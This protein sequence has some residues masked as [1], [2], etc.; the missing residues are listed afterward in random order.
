MVILRII[1]VFILVI[2]AYLWAIMPRIFNKPSKELFEKYFYA[3][4]GLY[5][6]KGDAPENSEKAFQKAV[7]EG[8]GIELDIQLSKD[9]IPVVFHD[10]SLKRVCKVPGKIEDYMLEE[11]RQFKLL[12]SSE[13][14]PT[15]EEVLKL[16]DG[17]VP[18]IIEIKCASHKMEICQIVY[19]QMKQ[20]K[21]IYCIESFHPLVVYW[22][23]KNAPQIMRGQLSSDFV[24]EGDK[25]FILRLLGNL[26]FNFLG[27]PDFIAYNCCYSERMSRK[28]CKKLY[29]AYMIAWTIQSEEQ[30]KKNEKEY[31]MF[32]FEGFLP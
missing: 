21:G 9:K 30:L 15:L 27:K 29:H 26:L 1:I 20:Y 3:H 17:K 19:E 25:R 4:R 11:L 23:R 7:K 24:R 14:I 28:L 10:E 13:T 22:F 12:N 32:I 2:I 5:D 8:Y 18:L 6:N 31:D 16:V